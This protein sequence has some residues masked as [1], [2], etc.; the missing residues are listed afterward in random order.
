MLA[1]YQEA[2]RRIVARLA[3][4]YQPQQVFLFGSVARGQEREGS[5]IDLLVV[6]DTPER[7]FD[8]LSTARHI[9][10][11]AHDGLSVDLLVYT[12]DEMAAKWAIGD[13]FI[14]EI[15][16]NGRRLYGPPWSCDL[17]RD[18]TR[19][20]LEWLRWAERDLERAHRGYREEDPGQA[21]YYVQQATEKF[22][23]AFLLSHGWRLR[24]IHDLEELLDQ[25]VAYAPELEELRRFCHRGNEFYVVDRY[26]QG[27]SSTL[28]EA[29]MPEAAA[30]LETAHRLAARVRRELGR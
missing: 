4:E 24:R 12:P 29:T 11:G 23:K 27:E 21:G 17:T 16:Q 19:Y 9:I 20:P 2:V 18:D 13:Q 8:R 7:F 15:T 28:E 5:D 10:A 30:A 1:L 6:K 14:D 3:A 22:L 26:P 25:A